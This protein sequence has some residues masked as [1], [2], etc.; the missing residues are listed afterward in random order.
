MASQ[1]GAKVYVDSKLEPFAT[2]PTLFYDNSHINIDGTKIYTD[3]VL[4]RL[5]YDK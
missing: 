2:N 1:Y 5:K 3:I 4:S